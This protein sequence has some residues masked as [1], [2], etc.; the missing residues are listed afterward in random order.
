MTIFLYSYGATDTRRMAV[1]LSYNCWHLS[2]GRNLL[3]TNG[4]WGK[5][6]LCIKASKFEKKT[7]SSEFNTL[8]INIYI[9]IIYFRQSWSR[10]PGENDEYHY[11]E[12]TIEYL[13]FCTYTNLRLSKD[14]E[15]DWYDLF[16]YF[17]LWLKRSPSF[18]T[19]RAMP[20]AQHRQMKTEKSPTFQTDCV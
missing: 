9:Q 20:M 12:V 3:W 15:I 13:S 1:C 7:Q 6:S 17:R 2:T 8:F 18:R 4:V 19:L 14:L 10:I 16:P 5:V 11:A